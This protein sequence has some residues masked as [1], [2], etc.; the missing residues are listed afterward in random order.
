MKN[1]VASEKERTEQAAV[2]S[3]PGKASVNEC[4]VWCAACDPQPQGAHVRQQG[5]RR[6]QA[7]SPGL[8][9]ERECLLGCWCSVAPERTGVTFAAPSSS[10]PGKLSSKAMLRATSRRQVPPHCQLLPG[11]SFSLFSLTFCILKYN[12]N[13]DNCTKVYRLLNYKPPPLLINS[14][15][16]RAQTRL[17][18]LSQSLNCP[19]PKNNLYYLNNHL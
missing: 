17:Y 1:S 9:P 5:H 10:V 4:Q 6:S 14:V 2:L 7:W 13:T 11:S 3:W 12:I 16:V 15:L 19:A 8:V 18:P